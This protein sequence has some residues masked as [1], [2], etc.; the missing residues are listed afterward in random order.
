VPEHKEPSKSPSVGWRSPTPKLQFAG[1]S[2]AIDT[3]PRYQDNEDKLMTRSESMVGPPLEIKICSPSPDAVP[4][5]DEFEKSLPIW[6][7]TP[8][9]DGPLA[10]TPEALVHWGHANTDRS[11]HTIQFKTQLCEWRNTKIELQNVLS[12]AYEETHVLKQHVMSNKVTQDHLYSL[13]NQ[14]KHTVQQVHD[15][16]QDV[17]QL[18]EI[19]IKQM[20]LNVDAV[21]DFG[22][23][24]CSIPFD[25]LSIQDF[26]HSIQSFYIGLMECY[27]KFYGKN[28]PYV[29]NIDHAFKNFLQKCDYV[30]PL[31]EG[32]TLFTGMMALI[33]HDMYQVDLDVIMCSAQEMWGEPDPVE[34]AKPP[35]DKLE[36]VLNDEEVKELAHEIV[37]KK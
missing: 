26:Y 7:R 19:A 18:I 6:L 16:S 3:A 36:P 1:T 17:N 30:E 10:F 5:T 9:L 8:L 24:L 13:H 12:S 32:I 34:V 22:T 2:R 29:V 23:I 37:E 11:E 4:T 31:P 35:I 25:T 14:V 21:R 28:N 27:I 20:S 15:A 33:I